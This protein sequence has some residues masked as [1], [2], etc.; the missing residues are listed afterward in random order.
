MEED[1]SRSYSNIVSGLPGPRRHDDSENTTNPSQEEFQGRREER[2]GINRDRNTL[3]KARQRQGPPCPDVL[4]YSTRTFTN[5]NYMSRSSYY[6][7]REHI[8]NSCE[9]VSSSRERVYNTTY[10]THSSREKVYDNKPSTLPRSY[11]RKESKEENREKSGTLPRYNRTPRQRTYSGGDQGVYRGHGRGGTQ[12]PS[13]RRINKQREIKQQTDSR[14]RRAQSLPKQDS[15][16][17]RNQLSKSLMTMWTPDGKCLSFADMLKG[18]SNNDLDQCAIKGPSSNLKEI[19]TIEQEKVT[20]DMNLKSFNTQDQSNNDNTHMET[21]VEKASVET[22]RIVETKNSKVSAVEQLEENSFQFIDSNSFFTVEQNETDEVEATSS[23]MPNLEV[24]HE[25][26]HTL[27]LKLEPC[28]ENTIRNEPI[29][30]DFQ[31]E[32]KDKIIPKPSISH[33]RSYANIL[34]E[35]LTMVRNVFKQKTK[36]EI[37]IEKEIKKINKPAE[38]VIVSNVSESLTL[39]HPNPNTQDSKTLDIQLGIPGLLFKQ[40]LERRNS[41]KKRKSRVLD[42]SLDITNENKQIS[43]ENQNIPENSGMSNLTENMPKVNSKEERNPN[44]K[45]NKSKEAHIKPIA[46][47]TFVEILS[48][49]AADIDKSQSSKNATLKRRLSKKKKEVVEKKFKDDIDQALHEIMVMEEELRARENSIKSKRS[50]KKGKYRK[51]ITDKKSELSGT[52][53]DDESGTD[54]NKLNLDENIP[55]YVSLPIVKKYSQRQ[56]TLII[57]DTISNNSDEIICLEDGPLSPADNFLVE[58]VSPLGIQE[59]LKE[60][61]LVEALDKFD[62]EKDM[63]TSVKTIQEHQYLGDHED[64][65][66][67]TMSTKTLD[68][69]AKS[70]NLQ[71]SIDQEAIKAQK[72]LPESIDESNLKKESIKI[73]TDWMIDDVGTIESSDEEPENAVSSEESRKLTQNKSLPEM[74]SNLKAHVLGNK[75]ELDTKDDHVK[76]ANDNSKTETLYRDISNDWMIDDVGTIESSDEEENTIPTSKDKIQQLRSEVDVNQKPE[77]EENIAE[78][79]ESSK[80]EKNNTINKDNIELYVQEDKVEEKICKDDHKPDISDNWMDDDVGVIESL[81]EQENINPETSPEV[82]VDE[83]QENKNLR[84]EIDDDWMDD[85]VGIIESSDEEENII[86]ETSP[87]VKVDEKQ[88]NKNVRPEI[89]DDWMDDDVGIIESSDEEDIIPSIKEVKIDKKQEKEKLSHEI[90]NDWMNDDVGTMELSD[91]DDEDSS[92][93]SRINQDEVRLALP[94]PTYSSI[95]A[96]EVSSNS[97]QDEQKKPDAVISVPGPH[98]TLIVA[99]D[100]HLKGKNNVDEDGYQPVVNKKERQPRK[101]SDSL[102]PSSEDMQISEA[103]TQK[104]SGF[105]PEQSGNEIS[106]SWMIDDVGTIESSDEEEENIKSTIKA[107]DQQSK[108]EINKDLKNYKNYK[109]QEISDDWMVDDVGIIESSDEEGNDAESNVSLIQN[110]FSKSDSMKQ[111]KSSIEQNEVMLALPQPTYSSIAAIEVSSNSLQDEQKKPDAVISVPGP[112]VTLIVAVDEHLKGKNNVDEDGYQPV[113][114]KKERQTRKVSD[115]LF[116]SSEDMQISEAILQKDSGFKSEQSGKEISDSWMVDDVGTIESSDEEEENI[117]PTIKAMDQQLMTE[118]NKDLKNCKNYK[119]Q[120]ISDD[121]M[122]D[123]VGIIESSDIEGDDAE[124]NVSLNQGKLTSITETQSL[125]EPNEVMLALPQPTY[126]SITAKEVLSN[127][128]QEEQK[129]PDAVISIPGPHVTLIVAADEHLKV[130]TCVDEEGYE[131]VFTKKKKIMNKISTNSLSE[132][133]EKKN[134][135][136]K[137]ETKTYETEQQKHYSRTEISEDWM[138]DDV[139]CIES[140]DE[141]EIIFEEGKNLIFDQNVQNKSESKAIQKIS[142]ESSFDWMIDEPVQMNSSDEDENGIVLLSLPTEHEKYAVKSETN[143]ISASS[144]STLSIHHSEPGKGTESET[145]VHQDAKCLNENCYSPTCNGKKKCYSSLCKQYEITHIETDGRGSAMSEAQRFS[146]DD[147]QFDEFPLQ[148]HEPSERAEKTSWA[149]VVSNNKRDNMQTGSPEPHKLI[150]KETPCPPLVIEIVEKEK[151]E[152]QVDSEGYT[153]VKTKNKSKKKITERKELPIDLIDKLDQPLCARPYKEEPMVFEE[154]LT[155]EE[156]GVEP[157]TD[158]GMINT[159]DLEIDSSK[160]SNECVINTDTNELVKFDDPWLAVKEEYV[161]PEIDVDAKTGYL[162]DVKISTKETCLGRKLHA[163]EAQEWKMDVQCVQHDSCPDIIDRSVGCHET[164]KSSGSS[165]LNEKSLAPSWMRK[166]IKENEKQKSKIKTSP[167]GEVVSKNKSE[168]AGKEKEESRVEEKQVQPE[169]EVYWRIKNKVKKK[170]RRTTSNTSCGSDPTFSDNSNSNSLSRKD[171]KDSQRPVLSKIPSESVDNKPDVSNYQ[172]L[173]DSEVVCIHE[174]SLESPVLERNEKETLISPEHAVRTME[175]RTRKISTCKETNVNEFINEIVSDKESME[176][177]NSVME[178][179]DED[180]PANLNSDVVI[181]IDETDSHCTES[182]M[183]DAVEMD[184]VSTPI[185]QRI[186][187]N[188]Q[189]SR[190]MEEAFTVQRPLRKAS[191]GDKLADN[192]LLTTPATNSF[193][194]LPVDNSCTAWINDETIPMESSNEE[195]LEI[196]EKVEETDSISKKRWVEITAKVIENNRAKS[197][198]KSR[199]ELPSAKPIIVCKSD[200]EEK[201]ILI[202]EDGFEVVESKISRRNRAITEQKTDEK[203]VSDTTSLKAVSDK[204]IEA[205]ETRYNENKERKQEFS[206]LSSAKPENKHFLNYSKDSFWLD[207]SLYDDAEN[208]FFSK[209]KQKIGTTQKPSNDRKDDD[210]EDDEIHKKKMKKNT[211]KNIPQKEKSSTGVENQ[212]LSMDTYCWTDESTYLSPKISL[213][214]PSTI[215][216]DRISDFSTK[217]FLQVSFDPAIIEIK[218]KLDD[219]RSGVRSVDEQLQLLSDDQLEGQV[220]IIKFTV[221]KLEDLT[222]DSAEIETRIQSATT[223]HGAGVSDL[224]VVAAELAGL[225]TQLVSLGTQAESRRGRLDNYILERRRRVTEIKK[226]QSLLIDLEVWLNEVQATL[227]S[228]LRLTS[229]KVV[230][231][232]IRGC[233]VLEEDLRVRVDQLSLL[234]RDVS[235]LSSNPD[236]SGFVEEMVSRLGG[237]QDTMSRTQVGLAG[238]LAQL[239]AALREMVIGYPEGFDIEKEISDVIEESESKRRMEQIRSTTILPLK[240]VQSSENL[241]NLPDLENVTSIVSESYST[242]V[243]HEPEEVLDHEDWELLDQPILDVKLDVLSTSEIR[244]NLPSMDEYPDSI[245]ESKSTIQSVTTDT[246]SFIPFQ[247]NVRVKIIRGKELQK[248]DT[249]RKSDPYVVFSY[250]GK[251]I[252]TDIQ[253]NTLTP[254]WNKEYDLV[255][256]KDNQ[257]ISFKVYDWE[258]VGKDESM[259]EVCL[260][261]TDFI[262]QTRQGP[263]WFKLENCKSGFILLQMESSETQSLADTIIQHDIQKESLQSQSEKLLQISK[264]DEKVEN[265]TK[266]LVVERV[267]S[268]TTKRT[269]RK[270]KIID[271][272]EHVTEETIDD[273]NRDNVRPEDEWVQIPIIRM[274]KI[275]ELDSPGVVITELSDEEEP[276]DLTLKP[277]MET[278]LVHTPTEVSDESFDAKA[279]EIEEFINAQ[280]SYIPSEQ[281]LSVDISVSAFKTSSASTVEIPIVRVNTETSPDFVKTSDVL[282]SISE[283]DHSSSRILEVVPE[284]KEDEAKKNWFVNIPIIRVDKKSSEAILNIDALSSTATPEVELQTTTPKVE[285]STTIAGVELSIS[286]SEVELSTE[287]PTEVEPS[288]EL[289]TEVE[290]SNTTAEVELS[291]ELPTEVD[292]STTTAEVELSTTTTEVKLSTKT[293]EVELSTTTNGIELVTATTEVQISTAPT[294]VQLSTATT[295]VKLSNTTNTTAEVEL[296]TATTE[297]VLSTTTAEIEPL[298]A[299]FKEEKSTGEELSITTNEVELSTTTPELG[300]STETTGVELSTVTAEKQLSTTTSEVELSTSTYGVELSTA[301][302]EVEL[303]STT[304]KVQLSNTEVDLSIATSQVELSAVTAEVQLSNTTSKVDLSTAT[305]EV[306]LS[307]ATSEVERPTATAQVELSTATT[308]VEL[309][310]ATTKVEISTAPTKVKLSTATTEVELSTATTKVEISTAPTKVKLSTATAEVELS[311]ATTEVD[312]LTAALKVE[313]S[314]ATTDVELSTLTVEEKL[315]TTTTGSDISI[316]TTE[317]ELSNTT[318]EVEPSTATTKVEHSTVN[319][320]IELLTAPIG[321]KL[322]TANP[323]AD[324]STKATE[325]EVSNATTEVELPTATTEV[326]LSTSTVEEKLLTTTTEVELSTATTEG[327]LS[328]STVEEKLSTKTSGM[329]LTTGTAKVEITAATAKVE[330]S[331][332]TTEEGLLTTANNE[333]LLASKIEFKTSTTGLEISN[334]SIPESTTSPVSHSVSSVPETTTSPVSHIVASVPETTTSPVSHSVTSVPESTT[335][336][337]SHSVTSV[338]EITTSPVSHS[339]A[340]VPET[341]TSPV[342]HSVTSVPET[343]TSPVSHSV[344][345]VPETT[346]SPVSHSVGSVPETTTSPVSHRVTSVPETTTTPVSHSVAS[347]PETTTSPVSHSVTSV[348]ETT[349]SPVSHSV[350]SVPE[351]TTSPVSHS[352]TSVPET[353]TSPVSHSVSFVPE[354]TTSPVSH[355][356]TSVPEIT[357]SPVSHSV[358]YI[359]ETTTSPVSHSVTSVPEITT[360]PVSHCVISVPETTTSPVSH[361][362]TSVPETTTSPV[363]QNVKSVPETPTSP[364]SQSVTSVPETTTSHASQSVRPLPETTTSPV[365][366]TVTSVPDITTSPVS[367]CVISVP[368][369]TTSPV[370]HSVTSVPETTTSHALQSV[371]SLPE[372]TTSPVSH[373]VT[374]IP[375]STA[376]TVSHIVLSVPETTHVS[377]SIM[378]VLETKTSSEHQSNATESEKAASFESQM[379]TTVPENTTSLIPHSGISVTEMK[380]SYVAHSVS[381]VPETVMFSDSDDV[382]SIPETELM[383]VPVTST[384]VVSL[385]LV[386]VTETTTTSVSHGLVSLLELSSSDSMIQTSGVSIPKT[387][388]K[389]VSVISTST[390]HVSELNSFPSRQDRES[391]PV[392]PDLVEYRVQDTSDVLEPFKHKSQE[393]VF[394]TIHGAKNLPKSDIL[395]KGDPYVIISHGHTQFRSTTKK[396]TANPEWNFEVNM[397]V[398][399][400]PVIKITVYDE[401]KLTQDDIIGEFALE[402]EHILNSESAVNACEK[403]KNGGE[404][405]Y[406]ISFQHEHSG[407]KDIGDNG[408]SS[409]I[410]IPSTYHLPTGENITVSHSIQLPS[411]FILESVTTTQSVTK[412]EFFSHYQTDSLGAEIITMEEEKDNQANLVREI[413]LPNISQVTLPELYENSVKYPHAVINDAETKHEQTKAAAEKLGVLNDTPISENPEPQGYASLDKKSEKFNSTSKLEDA[414]EDKLKIPSLESE[415]VELFGEISMKEKILSEKNETVVPSQQEM[416]ESDKID[417][418]QLSI[419]DQNETLMQLLDERANLSQFLPTSLLANLPEEMAEALRT[420]VSSQRIKMLS[421]LCDDSKEEIPAISNIPDEERNIV[422]EINELVDTLDEDAAK[423][424]YEEIQ[425]ILKEIDDFTQN[426]KLENLKESLIQMQMEQTRLL[427]SLPKELIS[428]L[429]SD[430]VK[431]I[432]TGLKDSLL[433]LSHQQETIVRI[434]DDKETSQLENEELKNSSESKMNSGEDLMEEL[435][436]LQLEQKDLIHNLPKDLL[437]NLPEEFKKELIMG[438][439]KSVQQIVDV[440]ETSEIN[441]KP[442]D[443]NQQK[444]LTEE[445]S[446]LSEGLLTSE[447]NENNHDKSQNTDQIKEKNKTNENFDQEEEEDDESDDV[448]LPPTPAVMTPWSVV[449]G[450]PLRPGAPSPD[451]SDGYLESPFSQLKTQISIS[452]SDSQCRR[453]LFEN[454]LKNLNVPVSAEFRSVSPEVLNVARLAVDEVIENAK[455]KVL[456]LNTEVCNDEIKILNDIPSLQ[457]KTETTIEECFEVLGDVEFGESNKSL[458]KLKIEDTVEPNIELG[459]DQIK[460]KPKEI[461]ANE[462]YFERETNKDQELPC[463]VEEVEFY[464]EENSPESLIRLALIADIIKQRVSHIPKSSFDHTY[465]RTESKTFESIEEIKSSIFEDLDNTR[466]NI[467]KRKVIIVQ[468]KI[469]TIVETV[470][471]WLD[472]VEYKILKVRK[473]SSIQKKKQELKNI[474]NEIEVIEETVDELIEVTELAVEIFNEESQVTV[475]SCLNLLK[476]QF[477]IVKLSHQDSENEL[478]ES[479]EKWD[480]FLDGLQMVESLVKDLRNNVGSLKE[481]DEVSEESAEALS[482]LE[483]CSKGH[484]NKLAYLILTAKGLTDTLPENKVP[485]NLFTLLNE[486]KCLESEIQKDREKIITLILSRQDYEDTLREFQDIFMIA[487]SFFSHDITVLDIKHLN[488]ELGRRKKFFLNLSHCLQILNSNQEMLSKELIEFYEESHQSINNRGLNILKQGTE[489]VFNIDMVISKWSSVNEKW[490]DMNNLVAKIEVDMSSLVSI[491]ADEVF[492]KLVILKRNMVSLEEINSELINLKS[493]VEGIKK[494]VNSPDLAYLPEPLNG[495]VSQLIFIHKEKLHQLRE[496]LNRW[497][498]YENILSTI[499][500]WLAMVENQKMNT[501]SQKNLLLSELRTYKDLEKEANSIFF[502]ALSILPMSDEDLQCQLHAQLGERINAFEKNLLI[503]EESVEAPKELLEVLDVMKTINEFASGSLPIIQS[504]EEII[505]LI[506]KLNFMLKTTEELKVIL[507]HL[508]ENDSDLGNLEVI[509]NMSKDLKSAQ[510]KIQRDISKTRCELHVAVELREMLA[511]L[512]LDVKDLRDTVESGFEK[513]CQEYSMLKRTKNLTKVMRT[514]FDQLSERKTKILLLLEFPMQK[515]ISKFQSMATILN[516]ICTNLEQLGTSLSNLELEVEEK[517]L[518]WEEFIKELNAL[519]KVNGRNTF[520]QEVHQARGHIDLDRLRAACVNIK[521]VQID[522]LMEEDNISRL[523][524]AGSRLTSLLNTQNSIE[525]QTQIESAIVS[526]NTVCSS[527]LDTLTRYTSSVLLWERF[528][529]NSADI[530]TW[531]FTANTNLR[532]IELKLQTDG[533]LEFIYNELKTVLEDE[534]KK[535]EAI[536]ELKEITTDI[537]V[538]LNMD[539]G[540]RSAFIV[541]VDDLT[542]RIVTLRDTIT[543]LFDT[544][545]RHKTEQKS[546]QTIVDES[547]SELCNM[548]SALAVP[549]PGL[550]ITE[551]ELADQ[552]IGTRNQLMR[553]C[554]TEA[555]LAGV[556]NNGVPSTQLVPYTGDPTASVMQLWQ[557]VFEDTLEKYNRVSASLAN[558]AGAGTLL[559]VWENHVDQVLSNLEEPVS[560]SYQ[561]IGEQLRLGSLHRVLLIQH[562]EL[563]LRCTGLAPDAVQQVAEKHHA[564]LD[565]L[566]ERSTVLVTRKS[567]WN[568]YC[569]NADKLIAWIREMEKEKLQ[570]SLKHLPVRR[571]DRLTLQLVELLDRVPHGEMLHR[572]LV[573]QQLEIQPNFDSSSI[574]AA[575]LE[576]HGYQERISSLKAGLKTWLDHLNRIKRLAVEYGIKCEQ[577]TKIIVN[578]RNHMDSDLP[579]TKEGIAEDIVMCKELLDKLMDGSETLDQISDLLDQ[580]HPAVSPS[581]IKQSSQRV[582]LLHQ[583]RSD[584]QHRVELR[585]AELNEVEN[586][587]SILAER[588]IQLDHWIHD[589]VSRIQNIQGGLDTAILRLETDM[590]EELEAKIEENKTFVYLHSQQMRTLGSSRDQARFSDKEETD[591]SQ[592][593]FSVKDETVSSQVRLFEKDGADDDLEKVSKKLFL[594]IESL[595]NTQEKENALKKKIQDCMDLLNELEDELT[596]PLCIPSMQE[597]DFTRL[598]NNLGSADRRLKNGSSAVSSLLHEH[599]LL[600]TNHQL[601]HK[602]WFNSSDQIKLIT[603]RW[604]N[605][606]SEMDRRQLELRSYWDQRSRFIQERSLLQSWI[607]SCLNSIQDESS[608]LVSGLDRLGRVHDELQV[609]EENLNILRSIYSSLASDGLLDGMGEMKSALEATL[610]SWTILNNQ[611]EENTNR[612]KLIQEN[613]YRLEERIKELSSLDEGLYQDQNVLMRLEEVLETGNSFRE[614]IYGDDLH[615]LDL[616]L[617]NLMEKKDSVYK[618]MKRIETETARLGSTDLSVDPTESQN[619]EEN[620]EIPEP[621]LSSENLSIQPF[622]ESIVETSEREKSSKSDEKMQRFKGLVNPG[623]ERIDSQIQVSTLNFEEDTGVQTTLSLLSPL[624][625]SGLGLSQCSPVV[626]RWTPDL[627]P[628]LEI[629]PEPCK[630]SIDPED[631]KYDHDEYLVI[632]SRLNLVLARVDSMINS[633][634]QT[635]NLETELDRGLELMGLLRVKLGALGTSGRRNS[636]KEIKDLENRIQILSSRIHQTKPDSLPTAKTIVETEPD[637]GAL[638]ETK[639]DSSDVSTSASS[640]LLCRRR[641]WRQL[642]GELWRLELWLDQAE[643]KLN[644]FIN[645]GT[646]TSIEALE[647][648]ILEHR[649][650]L[651]DLDSHK[652]IALSSNVIGSHLSEHCTDESRANALTDRLVT[653]NTSWDRVCQQATTWQTNLQTALLENNE[654]H[655]T[656]HQLLDWIETTKETVRESEPVNLSLPREALL[657]KFNKFT[658]LKADLHRCEPRV[659]SLQEAADQLE[660]QADSVSCR[661]VKRKLNLLSG[662]LRGLIQVCGIYCMNLSRGLGLPPPQDVGEGALYDSA[663]VLPLLSNQ[664]LG[665]DTDRTGSLYSVHNSSSEEDIDTGVLSRSYRFLGRVVRAALPIQAL[666]LLLLGVSSIVPLEHDELICTLQ[667]NLQRSL[668]PML[669]WSNGPPPI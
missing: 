265:T 253:K 549:E 614:N 98:V 237:L 11:G 107:M 488:D 521:N 450:L 499:Q 317:V 8:H 50:F 558:Q 604:G 61:V 146:C 555:R 147:E 204:N 268:R 120:E 391:A 645:Q 21:S 74:S 441:L 282:N 39:K 397:A 461:D 661:D 256:T 29:P 150:L 486:S 668:E 31:E 246:E 504:E 577:L 115:S 505:T 121:W 665:R 108:T 401:D 34:S 410:N 646:P 586:V 53:S 7:S 5:R 245:Q 319:T 64:T 16:T 551:L 345:S 639:E 589:F 134:T 111:T 574:S 492:E 561:S 650:F 82:K 30:K 357:T 302:T 307:T 294:E 52:L 27:D 290:L 154:E 63:F 408:D 662:S 110:K 338:P 293:A 446:Y 223:E 352:V 491:T 315:S 536:K 127:T 340:S 177:A 329:E 349:T 539:E 389:V 627:V 468:K 489:H 424:V 632:R 157:N 241:E 402:I 437:E 332:K 636:E 658:E 625:D 149:F 186:A 669:R 135:E 362:V 51:S 612:L 140:S 198:K 457:I 75:R 15:A 58:I 130:A 633:G 73:S 609:Q 386:S 330:L 467:K 272:V 351:T 484:R 501:Q 414:N 88:E 267:V 81:D 218:V 287:V 314:T 490:N 634:A 238:R 474:K 311:T 333:M 215:L 382:L 173:F 278:C 373:S 152:V 264:T 206:E 485:E 538:Q 231:D 563:V 209:P 374:S 46:S 128:L 602:T 79:V 118:I 542:H 618:S 624:P 142:L 305:A 165:R 327:E 599:E 257:L 570:L 213:L 649:E 139:G 285:L 334:I 479:E 33:I 292:L 17:S 452:D 339:V 608:D 524:V 644:Q 202:D 664:L 274:D 214:A 453:T 571:L 308:E 4:A 12:A 250:Q 227:T 87:E 239:Q 508:T 573:K 35:G 175:L 598:R 404:V 465:T 160:T 356:V 260:N 597:E 394:L 353:T 621:H 97:L 567:I 71:T 306:E 248:M 520:F 25:E 279:I 203:L 418:K 83:K 438:I 243:V 24:C 166:A 321:V 32:V 433:N 581:D 531:I 242:G 507:G 283:V 445:K 212:D 326:E 114:N 68:E 466:S 553:I 10:R 355:S 422:K 322:L 591:P 170:R 313:P 109:S 9:A 255:I 113:V 20:T 270:V 600:T 497:Q 131:Q 226:Y 364:V 347:V 331:T 291:T 221:G 436:D 483:T 263:K 14:T 648:T 1:I 194:G 548:T 261:I 387:L 262:N 421:D 193:A 23:E 86:P 269:I 641:D 413:F 616:L 515:K 522:H 303:S 607:T 47:D 593:P 406:S 159:A 451:E 611:L 584:L 601:Q 289:P 666:M 435:I 578:A 529:Q 254:N 240:S 579:E 249:F 456:N 568:E 288:T 400:D 432:E 323:G 100:E 117:K 348:P 565:K 284:H 344:T 225:K 411:N 513:V 38:K 185:E 171:L 478:E 460:A 594:S 252:K 564:V 350:T 190:E 622:Q 481:K 503:I 137:D 518:V 335:S 3:P 487:E 55:T 405:Y 44:S 94:Q 613:L 92:A 90:S 376:S 525:T 232:Q 122:V 540:G 534:K 138:I 22:T 156:S 556:R 425:M 208:K 60:K 533:D 26:A 381:L 49:S 211:T 620:L 259:G 643:R 458:S 143:L 615:R 372:T 434:E 224:Q 168:L 550:D 277:E 13:L 379:I 102:F 429:P 606:C 431:V 324:F 43:K 426:E 28:L 6:D 220:G 667:N 393:V 144:K 76:M 96:K 427:P 516:L 440:A 301:N 610:Q 654:F 72:A 637:P 77:K 298:T 559:K 447:I 383:S 195:D 557:R 233:Q 475:S 476:E 623:I 582:W 163:S 119:S 258:R 343:T 417:E 178:I 65:C 167:F 216:M 217:P 42:E 89:G 251:D 136:V 45:E 361:S 342:S 359:P 112:H 469:V 472:N 576:L 527:L 580:L 174:V 244:M 183:L 657:E 80:G 67:N 512:D 572:S 388:D 41:K 310:T 588:R 655:N 385:S 399:D 312:L 502:Q 510:E 153:C 569:L 280:Q 656:I 363:S 360:S 2:K 54:L 368:E 297:V 18:G 199:V 603:L 498:R 546:S 228:D 56:D 631:E 234:S 443:V 103:I 235:Q 543:N 545:K 652:S 375:E 590:K 275:D 535:E 470:S 180:Y 169:E 124:S 371:R 320:A 511:S 519:R 191:T 181:H 640:C 161:R 341:T 59:D 660:L 132:P 273:S 367:H 455:F 430:L 318:T 517:E 384:S 48:E 172:T 629:D 155:E 628:D 229:L 358:I 57:D 377:D 494:T 179:K 462:E 473:I 299:T 129:K 197:P 428:S 532:G 423:H 638:R 19:E 222:R 403:F 617:R 151:M 560:T 514:N 541:E 448:T 482:E 493:D 635:S 459:H 271:G 247:G 523:K 562:Q 554:G 566:C 304:S 133:D 415:H 69:D 184:R 104:D 309:S 626:E 365:S 70:L 123:D 642:E 651:L 37:I 325:A 210:D 106:D 78:N 182:K 585:I 236:V 630:E 407:H 105:K 537:C 189:T 369:T 276:L 471:K 295:E 495:K 370:S 444:E 148:L 328:T 392:S 116:P 164:E 207:K 396:N 91:D 300:L 530:R 575:R 653:V 366:H 196:Q 552:L 158:S 62:M 463:D 500:T 544:L 93:K 449:A 205:S 412:Q 528:L 619:P 398:T 596:S 201:D 480:E 409:L 420:E 101:V 95:V 526:Y 337:V 336:P 583:Q 316:V 464:Q 595:K 162:I 659:I 547:R 266:K 477:K 192:Q 188:R 66:K 496:F 36:D 439:E 230:R 592:V 145:F 281:E 286:S 378:S 395:G 509:G 200:E 126:S 99:V 141:E 416:V 647:E 587:S 176:I 442:M 346:T 85:D 454:P 419:S 40:D 219:L 296:S 605:V 390:G 125:I 187:F 663:L 506:N 354:T 84:S 380:T